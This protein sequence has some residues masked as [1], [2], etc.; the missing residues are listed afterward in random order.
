MYRDYFIKTI[1]LFN[2]KRFGI[3]LFWTIFGNKWKTNGFQSRL[4]L[5]NYL[6]QF[7]FFLGDFSLDAELLTVEWLMHLYAIQNDEHLD[8]WVLLVDLRWREFLA[9]CHHLCRSFACKMELLHH[10]HQNI[11]N[12]C[13]KEKKRIDFN[14]NIVTYI[15][16]LIILWEFSLINSISF[17]TKKYPYL[18]CHGVITPSSGPPIKITCSTFKRFSRNREELHDLISLFTYGRNELKL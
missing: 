8:R 11:R 5:S 14:E 13:N 16:F 12:D 18:D 2:W 17:K 4:I 7:G 3:K 6:N 15:K 1:L 10:R 9:Q